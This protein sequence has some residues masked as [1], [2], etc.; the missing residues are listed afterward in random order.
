MQWTHTD[1]VTCC[2]DDSSKDLPAR[3]GGGEAVCQVPKLIQ[4]QAGHGIGQDLRTKRG[5]A[6]S[7][8]MFWGLFSE[9]HSR[10]GKSARARTHAH[11]FSSKT[12]LGNRH[13]RGIGGSLQ[14]G[15]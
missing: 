4:H 2:H 12:L 5:S 15:W 7:G 9:P 10:S 6:P 13:P 8:V 1:M 11:S 14:T 3:V